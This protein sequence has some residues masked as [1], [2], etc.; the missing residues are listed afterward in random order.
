M[1]ELIEKISSRFPNCI[2]DKIILSENKQREIDSF[3]DEN[4]F[5][6]TN[7]SYVNFLLIYSGLSY[8]DDKTDED[9]TLY[10][11]NNS[12]IEFSDKDYF[13]EPFLDSKGYF[14]FGHLSLPEQNKFYDFVFNTKKA[15]DIYIKESSE[16]K[17]TSYKFLCKSFDELLYKITM[18]E[19]N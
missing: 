16:K 5:L 3:I 1:N 4:S 10:G 19:I 8:F 12:G 6:K 17:N 13:N 18:K 9:L 15:M 7:I 2:S 14:L 11:F